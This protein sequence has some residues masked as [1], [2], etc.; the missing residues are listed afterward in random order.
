MGKYSVG[1]IQ[2]Q[3]LSYELLV[4]Y[5]ALLSFDVILRG[6]IGLLFFFC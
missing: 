5:C 2:E 1:L 3:H 4:F 6:S